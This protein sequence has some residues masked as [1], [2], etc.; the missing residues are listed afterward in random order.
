MAGYTVGGDHSMGI[1]ECI[2]LY[3][4]ECHVIFWFDGI[5]SNVLER[6]AYNFKSKACFFDASG[7]SETSITKC[8][9]DAV[10]C[11]KDLVVLLP[12][13]SLG[14]IFAFKSAAYANIEPLPR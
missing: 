2:V 11:I 9:T 3:N 5:V 4:P 13:P 7:N 14:R 12:T 10:V 8:C 6:V 1:D